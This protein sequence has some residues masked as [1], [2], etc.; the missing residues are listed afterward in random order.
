MNNKKLPM[1]IWMLGIVSL[2]MDVS[3]EMIHSLLPLFL[4]VGLGTSVTVVGLIEGVAE[5]T[6]MIV[7]L[8]SG[9]LS[10]YLGKRKTLAVIGYGLGAISKPLFAVAGTAGLVFTARFIDRIGKGIRGAP[11][12]ALIADLAPPEIRGAA[13]GLRQSLDTVGAFLGP[14]IAI[15]LMLLWEN[16]FRAVF[17]VAGIPALLAVAILLAGVREPQGRLPLH[18][19]PIDRL[20]LMRLSPGY[21]RV[22]AVGITFTLA[23]F[24]EAFL[25][26][27]A[28]HQGLAFAWIPMVFVLLNFIYAITAYPVGKLSDRINHSYLLVLGLLTLL[29]ADLILAFTSDLV[30]MLVG[31]SLWGLHMGI[32]Q[33]LLATMIANTAPDDLRGTA[34]GLFNLLTGLALLFAS[35]LAGLLWDYFGMKATF[36]AGAIFCVVSLVVVAG[37]RSRPLA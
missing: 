29:L 9:A 4:V 16:D 28:E 12:D 37:S 33:G 17:W 26:L 20:Q 23:R 27:R 11:R 30:S 36:T 1:S 31:I 7:K 34:F 3:S 21:W 24:S 18:R 13:Y 19:N 5:A 32:T 35:V 6:A 8:F 22:V 14:V 25:L 15:A 10:D 2:L